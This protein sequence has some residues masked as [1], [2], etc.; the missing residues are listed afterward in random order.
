MWCIRNNVIIKPGACYE[1]YGINSI[2]STKIIFVILILIL[3]LGTGNPDY[4]QEIMENYFNKYCRM[5]CV[6]VKC[7]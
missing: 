6:A 3:I 2:A 5:C 4:I 7:I 1:S